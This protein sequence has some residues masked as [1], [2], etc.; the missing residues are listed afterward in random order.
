VLFLVPFV[1]IW[2]RRRRL[3]AGDDDGGLLLLREVLL[4]FVG[5]LALFGIVLLPLDI[6]RSDSP[7]PTTLAVVIAVYWVMTEYA[8]RRIRRPF[9]CSSDQSLAESYR[10]YFF[11]RVAF[12]QSIALFGFVATF[13]TG[14]KWL[15]YFALPFTAVDYVGVAPTRT[16]LG[17][18]QERLTSDGCHRSLTAAVRRPPR[19]R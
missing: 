17:R 4:S 9:D 1:G 16:N 8:V 2:L 6:E 18:L 13:V 15:Y 14:A 5:A 11:L 3:A 19:E 7:S 10:M 12:A